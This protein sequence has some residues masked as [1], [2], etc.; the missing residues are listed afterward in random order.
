VASPLLII[1]EDWA[2]GAARRPAKTT[3]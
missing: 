3:P 1:Y 2:T